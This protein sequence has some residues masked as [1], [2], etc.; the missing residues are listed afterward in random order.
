[1]TPDTSVLAWMRLGL[2]GLRIRSCTRCGAETRRSWQML[3]A[4]PEHDVADCWRRFVCDTCKALAATQDVEGY[5]L[6]PGG[7]VRPEDVGP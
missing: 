5:G 6:G 2:H 4:R 1:M 7:S 3:A